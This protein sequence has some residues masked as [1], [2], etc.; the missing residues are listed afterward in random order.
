MNAKTAFLF[1]RHHLWTKNYGTYEAIAAALEAG[2]LLPFT[3]PDRD[4]DCRWA[5][6]GAGQ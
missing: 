5:K 1:W 4:C 6:A 3:C 2:E